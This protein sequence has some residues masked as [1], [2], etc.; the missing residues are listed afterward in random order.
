MIDWLIYWSIDVTHYKPSKQVLINLFHTDRFEPESTASYEIVLLKKAVVISVC[1]LHYAKKST[2]PGYV[3]HSGVLHTTVC[4][5]L[6]LDTI[7]ATL[8]S[9]LVC[10]YAGCVCHSSSFA[11]SLQQ[12]SNGFLCFVLFVFLSFYNLP[13]AH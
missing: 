6:I 10:R 9:Y 11:L 13:T 4:V 7:H 12:S 8:T 3:E 5:D 2:P 1:T